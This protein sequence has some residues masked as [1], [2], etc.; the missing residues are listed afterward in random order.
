MYGPNTKSVDLTS[1]NLPEDKNAN[2]NDIINIS[3]DYDF[4]ESFQI[5]FKLCN[6]SIKLMFFIDTD[7]ENTTSFAKTRYYKSKGSL[8]TSKLLAKRPKTNNDETS[9]SI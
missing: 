6:L 1:L 5:C 4:G 8:L 7:S 9:K 3:N 2:L